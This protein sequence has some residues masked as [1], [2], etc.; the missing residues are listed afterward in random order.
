MNKRELYQ[1]LRYQ[2][3][4]PPVTTMGPCAN[5]CG[6]W[7]RGS[8]EC[9]HCLARKLDKELGNLFAS[10]WVVW[11]EYTREAEASLEDAI[12]AR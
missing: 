1:A 7:A 6:L 4:T 2:V 11:A 10:H 8:A 5:G 3:L 12:N 9:K